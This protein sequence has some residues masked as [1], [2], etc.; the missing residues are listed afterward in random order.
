M[1]K[2]KFKIN[3]VNGKASVQKNL[4]NEQKLDGQIERKNS[5]IQFVPNK[6]DLHFDSFFDKFESRVNEMRLSKKNTDKI[7]QLCEE[8]I[9]ESLD[10]CERSFKKS[11]KNSVD[12]ISDTKQYVLK[13]TSS[14]KTAYLR[15]KILMQNK[16]YVAPV[17][18]AMGLKWKTKIKTDFDLPD[19][20]LMQTTF[21][22]VPPSQTLVKL[23][24]NPEI[25]SI[26]F[27][28]NKQKHTCCDGIYKDYC[29]GNVSKKNEIFLCDSVILQFGV[30]EFDVCCPIKSKATIHKIFAV[31][32]TIRNM[33]T[34]FSS[35]LNNI[36]LVAL[37]NSTNF[38]DSGCC[39]HQHHH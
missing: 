1:S 35:R 39:D 5:I 15:N 12:I 26:F 22:F 11:Q 25:Q 28:Y 17:A 20:Q 36:F 31:Y 16:N 19:H 18:K 13:K 29:C 7:Y 38:K 33:P 30:D 37:S 14:V 24:S 6:V 3:F 27:D 21:Q 8:I 32:F 34:K 10:L 9:C 4:T 2:N 23:F